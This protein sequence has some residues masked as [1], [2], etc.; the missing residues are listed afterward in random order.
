VAGGRHL[1]LYDGECGLC[2][3]LNRFV[4]R[5]DRRDRF[6]FA[7]LQGEVGRAWAARLGRDPDDL[8]TFLVVADF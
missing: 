2:N 6:R 7:A 1:L 8:S 3:R 5:R 4:L